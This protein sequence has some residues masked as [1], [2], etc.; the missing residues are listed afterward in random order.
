M[1]LIET[2]TMEMGCPL[3]Q[4]GGVEQ[5]EYHAE[6]LDGQCLGRI[7]AGHSKLEAASD[8]LENSLAKPVSHAMERVFFPCHVTDIIAVLGAAAIVCCVVQRALYEATE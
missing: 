4:V 1:A 6:H 2:T 7:S 5:R 3:Q 8:S